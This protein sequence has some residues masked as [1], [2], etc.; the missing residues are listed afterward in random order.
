MTTALFRRFPSLAEPL[1]HVSLGEFPT[2][3]EPLD[4]WA[5]HCGLGANALWAKRDDLTSPVYGGNKVRK[6]EFTLGEALAHGVTDV[7]T[8]GGAG[9]NHALATAIHASRL[10]LR[11]HL[12]LVD[13]ANAAYVAR[14]LLAGL[15]TPATYAWAPGEE[16][17]FVLA[18]SM[19]VEMRG[20]GR[21]PY[22]LP[23]GGSSP[24]GAVGFVSAALELAE[25]VAAAEMPQPDRLYVAAGTL[26]TSAGLAL[27]LRMAG[28]R[29]RVVAVRVLPADS[30]Y[31]EAV[32]ALARAAGAT[33]ARADPALE[34]PVVEVSDFDL[35]DEAFG[36]GYAVFTEAGQ[37]AVRE[38]RERAGLILEGT[39]T[40]KTAAVL[41]DDARSGRLDGLTAILWDTHN[42][43]PL[44]QAGAA[45]LD[46]L[47][48]ELAW[49]LD[50]PLQE[51]EREQ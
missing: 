15:T 3:V 34:L 10:G 8:F 14:N 20:A 44:P 30:V 16:E 2:R 40:G 23:F 48:R 47:P 50:A 19:A 1:T 18:E 32:V 4:E 24:L 36:E 11:V 21:V 39:Y 13:Q 49:Y 33:L 26:A 17:A 25:Q 28:L 43:R 6:L 46:R 22:V 38:A 35:R 9:S 12:V 29:T 41:A 7:I 45:E 5:A 51:L 31:P 37:H 27:G 42:S